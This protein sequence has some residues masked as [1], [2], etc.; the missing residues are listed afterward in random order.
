MPVGLLSGQVFSH[1]GELCLVGSHGASLLPGC[2]PPPTECRPQR[3]AR[4]DGDS[5]LGA[6]ARWGIRNWRRWRCL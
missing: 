1:F 5:E 3:P 2:M 4:L 6:V